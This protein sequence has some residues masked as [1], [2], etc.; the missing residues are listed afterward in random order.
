MN[1]SQEKDVME[2]TDHSN[3]KYKELN[4][5]TKHQVQDPQLNQKEPVQNKESENCLS[6]ADALLMESD[7]DLEHDAEV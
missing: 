1:L 5:N 4:K 3:A 2:G 6:K 7:E